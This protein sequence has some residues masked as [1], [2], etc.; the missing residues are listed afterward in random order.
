M[1]FLM[2]PRAYNEL[3][4]RLF[5]YSE[6][7]KFEWSVGCMLAGGPHHAT[8][9]C[10]PPATGKSSLEEIIRA[11]LALPMNPGP[12]P[13]VVFGTIDDRIPWDEIYEEG[14][15]Y[16][17]VHSFYRTPELDDCFDL[18]VELSGETLPRNHFY[19]LMEMIKGEER[20]IIHE[21]FVNKYHALG[22]GFIQIQETNR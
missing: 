15:Y 3:A 18:V 19:T 9:L 7:E 1:P 4:N 8:V 21:L 22:E 17:F 10:S 2:P 5:H 16:A 13:R 6:R 11:L 20:P 12:M 14:D